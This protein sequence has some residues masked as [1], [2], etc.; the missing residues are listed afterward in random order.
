MKA[1]CSVTSPFS[2]TPQ[3]AR[4]SPRHTGRGEGVVTAAARFPSCTQEEVQVGAALGLVLSLHLTI[5]LELISHQHVKSFLRFY[6]LTQNSVVWI[7]SNLL[8]LSSFHR[9]LRGTQNRSVA[10]C[11]QYHAEM[12]TIVCTMDRQCWLREKRDI[13]N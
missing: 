4:P 6:T 12:N 8:N 11:C 9:H 7:S 13:H 1:V 10:G 3:P 2:P 5:S